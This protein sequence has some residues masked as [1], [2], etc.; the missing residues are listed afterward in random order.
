MSDYWVGYNTAEATMVEMETISEV[1]EIPWDIVT[2]K[3]FGDD[4]YELRNIVYDQVE[5]ELNERISSDPQ[6][7]K[8]E[9]NLGCYWQAIEPQVRE[10]VKI[11]RKKGYNT[12][13]SGFGVGQF[14][15]IDGFFMIDEKSKNFLEMMGVKVKT[16]DDR[17]IIE[18]LPNGVTLDEI[19]KQ[20]NCIANILPN[21]RYYSE[22]ADS[23]GALAF[24]NRF[25]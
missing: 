20:W 25:R 16:G 15:S 19:T 4:F 6:P 2:E 18:W 17:T 12:A 9:L 11:M 13:S 1:W 3:N 5:R 14:Q 10:A 23:L 21:L 7:T 24:R 8:E 22:P